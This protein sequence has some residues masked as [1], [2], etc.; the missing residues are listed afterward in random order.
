MQGKGSIEKR[1]KDGYSWRLV[2]SQGYDKAGKKLRQS[3]TVKVEGRTL[4]SRKKAAERE[5]SLFLAETEKADFVQPKKLTLEEYVYQ[6]LTDHAENQLSPKTIV[7]YKQLLKDRILP[8]LGHI[9]LQELKPLHL[10]K[11]YSNLQESGIR[12]DKKGGPLSSST[13]RKYH[14]ILSS[15]LE[16]AV[17]WQLISYNP[18]TK[19]EPPKIHHREMQVFDLEKASVLLNALDNEELKFQ[20]LLKLAIVTGLRRGELM[21]LQWKNVDM[22]KGVINVKYSIAY[23]PGEGLLL[24]DPKNKSSV[25]KVSIPKFICDQLR[26]YEKDQK[27]RRLKVGTQWT[28]D[29]DY[30]F[31]TW[32]GEPMHPDT[33]TKWFPKFLNKH[34]ESINTDDSLSEEAK[35]ALSLPVV[36]FHML[37]HTAATL[38]IDKGLNIKA[39]SSRLGHAQTST[40]T[41]IYAHALQTADKQAADIMEGIFVPKKD[42]EQRKPS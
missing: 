42:E 36:N 35:K 30:I 40:T 26:L 22:E 24:K 3:K 29:S 27:A 4:D 32:N 16:K 7:C 25:R 23:I 10:V 31:T 6:W 21:A 17:K 28:K 38:L 13:I 20:L 39:V 9:K 41:N 5:L 15:M 19:V 2:V 33:V 18:C 8:A 12:E 34:N 11:F 37:R 1:D 14:A